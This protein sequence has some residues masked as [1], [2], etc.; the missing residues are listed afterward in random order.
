M[1]ATIVRDDNTVLVDGKA[2]AVD[3]SSMSPDIR[4]VQW[5]DTHGSVEY[6]NLPGIQPD[7]YKANQ[8][9]DSMAEFQEILDAYAAIPDP[10]P[11]DP[12][13]PYLL[14]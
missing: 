2:K 7:E 11:P 13:P 8:P 10:P 5:Y 9:I 4:V 14:G 3:C 12:P 6:V 1:R